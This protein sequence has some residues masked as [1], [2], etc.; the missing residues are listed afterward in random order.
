MILSNIEKMVSVIIRCS[1]L[2]PEIREAVFQCLVRGYFSDPINVGK[3]RVNE[4]KRCG[5][6]E[7][8]AVN[9]MTLIHNRSSIKDGSSQRM[10]Q[11]PLRRHV[12]EVKT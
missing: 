1:S 7:C 11:Q 2:I 6:Q 8:L 5:R 10:I 4:P 12:I 9:S 3:G